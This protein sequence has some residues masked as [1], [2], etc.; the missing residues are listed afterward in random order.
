MLYLVEGHGSDTRIS[1]F[2]TATSLGIINYATNIYDFVTSGQVTVHRKDV[3]Y[4]ADHSIHFEDGTSV[5]VEGMVEV[6]GWEYAPN[7][8]FKPDNI[9]SKLGIPSHRY[10]RTDKE[11]LGRIGS[12]SRY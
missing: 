11:H 3:A 6:T 7:I 8:R 2:W 9:A 5:A 12:E 10:R 1:P 4:L